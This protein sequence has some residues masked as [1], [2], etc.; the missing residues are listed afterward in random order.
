MGVE[1]YI[2]GGAFGIL[3]AGGVK[4]MVP[5]SRVAVN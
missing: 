1:D 5:F 3:G 2:F 4:L